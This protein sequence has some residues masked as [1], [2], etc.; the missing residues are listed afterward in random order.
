MSTTGWHQLLVVTPRIA[1]KIWSPSVTWQ[2][3]IS[4]LILNFIGIGVQLISHLSV[5]MRHS[6]TTLTY[7]FRKTLDN[8]LY[9]ISAPRPVSLPSL[10]PLLSRMPFTTVEPEGWLPL[11]TMVTFRP[12]ISYASARRKAGRQASILT[13]LHYAGLSLLGMAGTSLAYS[14]LLRCMKS[15]SK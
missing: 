11:Y 12:D 13:G 4:E 5:E 8:I 2:W 3:T 6:V 10:V 9:T 1:I 15:S 7:L 14:I